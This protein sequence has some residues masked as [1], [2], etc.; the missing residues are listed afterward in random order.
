MFGGIY[1]NRRVFITGH[2]GFKGSWLAYFLHRLDAEIMGYALPPN[3][4]PNHWNLLHLPVKSVEND[5]LG[6]E[7]LK[8]HIID[9]QPEIVFHLAAQPLVRLSYKEPLQTFS[10]NIIGTANVLEACRGVVSVRAVVVVTSDKCYEN[11]EWDRAYCETDPMGGHDPYSASKGCAELVTKSYRNSFFNLNDYAVRHNTLVATARAGNVI[12]GGDWAQDR[13]V[14]DIMRSAALGK[15]EEIRSPDAVRPWQHVL[16]PL[17]GYLLLGQRLFEGRKEYAGA[18][19]FGPGAESNIT[20]AEVAGSLKK[21]WDK[22]N[23]K[24]NPQDIRLHEAKLLKLDCGKAERLLR[25]HGIWNTEETL[26]LTAGWY[27]DFYESGKLNTASDFAEYIA[28][29]N[30][31]NITWAD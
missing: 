10:T 17:S 21:Y 15:V 2:T 29:A 23:I 26:R 18:W 9:F 6:L 19:N 1:K 8:K 13:L 24:A 16:E 3:T 11:R 14:P 20:V 7:T 28:S 12:G 22:V 31:R 25:W 4:E 27:R 5:I 30:D